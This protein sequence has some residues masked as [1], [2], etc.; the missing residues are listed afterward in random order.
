MDGEATDAGDHPVDFSSVKTDGPSPIKVSPT[1][2]VVLT[3]A[4]FSE[5]HALAALRICRD[6]LAPA[7]D[8]LFKH[9]YA[10]DLEKAVSALEQGTYDDERWEDE[11]HHAPHTTL[12]TTRAEDERTNR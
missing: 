9:R 5:R 11:A 4:G 7:C 12:G 2:V 8:W 6:E 10:G 1:S 3:N